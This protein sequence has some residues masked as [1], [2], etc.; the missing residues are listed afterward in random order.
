VLLGAGVF[1]VGARLW[2]ADATPVEPAGPAVRGASLGLFASDPAYDYSDMIDELA[3][4]GATDV[5]VVV[6]LV[7][8]DVTSHDL[9][10][11]DGAS[12]SFDTVSRTLEFARRRGL[13]TGLMPIV[14]LTERRPDEWRGVLAPAASAEVWFDAY[15]QQLLPLVELADDRGV[16]WVGVGS[17]LSSLEGQEAQWRGLVAE[18]RATTEAQL[19][20]AANWDRVDAVPFWDAVDAVG[21]SGYF[22]LAPEGTRPTDG[23]LAAA[24]A[25][26]R[27]S[28]QA[29]A[30]REG[31][32]IL[33]AEVGYPSHALAA[34]RPWDHVV[35]APAD[36]ELQAQLWGAFCDAFSGAEGVAGFYA[37]NWFGRGGPRD[38]GY[39]P[40]GKPA[41][42]TLE[43]CWGRSTWD[44]GG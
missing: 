4:R 6:P 16:A 24:W 5:L 27:R 2:L 1:A 36:L 3:D 8:T 42:T 44:L 14:R 38:V 41:A 7:Q 39:T 10:L 13:R 29:T 19:F 35:D 18:V 12:P 11:V 23:A 17:E 9:A 22:A 37:W 34:A 20:Y 15:R 43:G 40:R 25:G 30:S 28:L 33:F 31:R 21:V 32:P 26:P